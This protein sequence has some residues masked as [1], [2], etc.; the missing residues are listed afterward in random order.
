[1]AYINLFLRVWTLIEFLIFQTDM[2]PRPA[3]NIK[4]PVP[5]PS[6]KKIN[7][8][9][10]KSPSKQ[11][12]Q[13]KKGFLGSIL[14]VLNRNKGP[15]QMHL[16]EDKQPTIV[17][18]AQKGQW[19]NTAGDDE[20]D[21]GPKGPPPKDSELSGAPPPMSGGPSSLPPS[22]PYQNPPAPS[23]SNTNLH[24]NHNSLP[25]NVNLQNRQPSQMPSVM[26]GAIP[27][28]MPQP[29]MGGQPNKYKQA[30]GLGKACIQ[31]G[32]NHQL[33]SEYHAKL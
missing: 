1:V 30:K 20:G 33:F 29:T 9:E 23:N 13:P 17:W 11:Q 14:G 31:N 16:P 15:N 5:K 4:P 21:S 22:Q 32:I 26:N 2:P 28:S 18:D 25:P 10:N 19:V 24:N 3:D 8:D 7:K 6:E 27:N 12:Q